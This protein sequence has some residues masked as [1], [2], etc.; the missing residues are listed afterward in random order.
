MPASPELYRHGV[1]VGSRPTEKRPGA[2][3]RG[4]DVGEDAS[5]ISIKQ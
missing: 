5:P 1:P 2:T 3:K 4:E